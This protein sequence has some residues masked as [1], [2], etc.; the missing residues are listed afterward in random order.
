MM[1][2]IGKGTTYLQYYY[3]QLE[4]EQRGRMQTGIMFHCD[5]SNI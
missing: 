3:E 2:H 4:L 1:S 5:D